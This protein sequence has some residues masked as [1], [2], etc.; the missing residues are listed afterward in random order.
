M[1][2]LET[3]RLR[4]RLWQPGDVEALVRI[5]SD[6]EVARMLGET[7]DRAHAEE[8]IERYA[9]SWSE[10]GFG[11]LAVEEKRSG[12][13]IGRIGLAYADEWPVGEDKVEIGWMI[14]R[15]GWGR[16]FA[17]EGA[18]AALA[19]GFEVVQLPRIISF[20]LPANAASRRVM[21]KCGFGYRGSALWRGL[22]HVWYELDRSRWEAA[23]A[24]Q[25][26]WARCRRPTPA[27]SR[28]AR[29]SRSCSAGCRSCTTR[30]PRRPRRSQASRR[31]SGS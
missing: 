21:E 22:E 1:P 14:D 4:L 11:R 27:P 28:R 24:G 7:F 12:R 20:T 30:T 29:S 18:R 31:T 9:R 6:P 3:E 8:Q 26:L 13:F 19:H 25:I 15:A 2:V 23:D 16:G 17:T 10:R 5:Y